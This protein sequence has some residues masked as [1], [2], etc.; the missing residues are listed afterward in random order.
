[1]PTD[2]ETAVKDRAIKDTVIK[3]DA[4]ETA[5]R[6]VLQSVAAGEKDVEQ[7]LD[8]MNVDAVLSAHHPFADNGI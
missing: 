5:L 3:D 1:M 8:E 6:D 7:A 4:K 2:K